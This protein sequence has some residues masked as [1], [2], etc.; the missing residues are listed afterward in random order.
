MTPAGFRVRSKAENFVLEPIRTSGILLNREATAFSD[1][2]RSGDRDAIPATRWVN[3]ENMKAHPVKALLQSL[4]ASLVVLAATVRCPGQTHP[5]F[6][7]PG[8][9]LAAGLFGLRELD[10]HLHAG[11]ERPADLKAWI[12]LAVA[13]GRKVILLLDQLVA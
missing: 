5:V 7:L 6:Q 11:M 12:D 8:Q 4:T 13:D 3:Q 1:Q 2:F 9:D 10:L